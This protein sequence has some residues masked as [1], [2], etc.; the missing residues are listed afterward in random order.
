MLLNAWQECNRSS[1]CRAERVL[2]ANNSRPRIFTIGASGG[3]R[4][5]AHEGSQG[6]SS[7]VLRDALT[8]HVGHAII[9]PS[10][11]VFEE[12]SGRRVH[13]ELNTAC[14]TH[15]QPQRK[16]FS[17]NAS[18]RMDQRLEHAHIVLLV[19]E[20]ADAYAHIFHQLLPQLVMLMPAARRASQAAALSSSA[21]PSLLLAPRQGNSVDTSFLAQLLQPLGIQGIW[22]VSKGVIHRARVASMLVLP[23][24]VCP[25]LAVYGR[26]S[27]AQIA[28]ALRWQRKPAAAP[29]AAAVTGAAAS[30]L[31]TH[32]PRLV[33]YL[34][35]GDS[36]SSRH[37]INDEALIRAVNASLHPPFELCVVTDPGMRQTR[38]SGRC[39]LNEAAPLEMREL[40]SR[41]RVLMGPHGSALANLF[42]A[43]TELPL[44]HII[45]FNRIRDGREGV[46]NLH[47]ALG[48]ERSRYWL[49]PPIAAFSGPTD[50]AGRPR[51]RRSVMVGRDSA[52]A[53]RIVEQM[54]LALQRDRDKFYSSAGTGTHW[55]VPIWSVLTILRHAGVANHGTAVGPSLNA[56]RQEQCKVRLCSAC[57][58]TRLV[59]V[60]S[61]LRCCCTREPI[62]AAIRVKY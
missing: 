8:L 62:H 15:F 45:E 12:R 42:F 48:G 22:R 56:R 2:I 55:L 27:L 54:P 9:S 38:T 61:M 39:G 7:R 53:P 49:L 17:V 14:H 21:H 58:M 3:V 6:A 41:T 25:N 35:R 36:V 29:T 46:V 11:R 33:V 18:T 28:A 37:I 13:F 43:H 34:R 26:G 31:L 20:Y 32:E 16:A 59:R 51:E 5:L 52:G 60:V 23:Y 40:M 57:D 44:M 47:H 50:R 19:Q 4:A 30:Q 24:G 10:G 1:W